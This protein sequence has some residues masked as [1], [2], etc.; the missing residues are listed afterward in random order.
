MEQRAYTK[1]FSNIFSGTLF[2]NNIKRFFFLPIVHFLYSLMAPMLIY[3]G[4]HSNYYEST[5]TEETIIYVGNA[6]NTLISPIY[7]M[8]MACVMVYA[9]F[10]YLYNTKNCYMMHA[11][12]I[13]RLCMYVTNLISAFVMLALPTGVTMLICIPMS[14]SL[15]VNVLVKFLSAYVLFILMTLFFISVAAF[16]AMCTGTG[17]AMPILYI[18]F[19]FLGEIIIAIRNNMAGIFFFGCRFDYEGYTLTPVLRLNSYVNNYAGRSDF[20]TSAFFRSII[21][22]IILQCL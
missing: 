16:V 3:V 6:I 17:A 2:L 12:P 20:G 14:L 21:I 9:V 10:S 11:F 1:V 4:A 5:S 19:N 13:T 22:Y 8:I 18:I 7:I 15:G